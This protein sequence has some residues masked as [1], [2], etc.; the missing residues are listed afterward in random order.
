MSSIPAMD[1][2]ARIQDPDEVSLAQAAALLPPT[3]A[4]E[5]R[6]LASVAG[7]AYRS[8]SVEHLCSSC[9]D[10]T[11]G[12]TCARCDAPLCD[13]HLPAS[14]Q[15]CASCEEVYELLEDHQKKNPLRLPQVY[16]S[17]AL[18]CGLVLL[19]GAVLRLRLGT[20]GTE[21]FLLGVAAIAC[22][23]PLGVVMYRRWRL[24][25]QFLSERSTGRRM[26]LPVAAE[27]SPHSP[28]WPPH[29]IIYSELAV[30]GLALSLLF[31]IPLMPLVG[32]ILG[33]VSLTG[34]AAHVRRRL[35]VS[36]IIVG[37]TLLVAQ[38]V[39]LG[40]ALNYKWF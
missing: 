16:L 15:H 31:F 9:G 24:R 26:A 22:L 11:S 13:L 27:P 36:S 17:Y 28:P 39:A 40:Y 25:P 4:M 20:T 32:A 29:H 2:G 34:P 19:A 37:F 8:A 7:G 33:V 12:R 38:A 3:S 1:P 5:T 21:L 6:S 23:A 35:A 14:S 18:G 10:V 30:T